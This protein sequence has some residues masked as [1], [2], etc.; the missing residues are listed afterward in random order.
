MEQAAARQ[1][2]HPHD[3]L[4]LVPRLQPVNGSEQ[5]LIR[6]DGKPLQGR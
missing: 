4:R 6:A 3:R 2:I 5:E 1:R